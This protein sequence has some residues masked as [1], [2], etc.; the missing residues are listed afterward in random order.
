M[1]WKPQRGSHLSLHQQILGWMKERI[2]RG[3]W[4]IHTKLPPQRKLAEALEV[5]RSTIIHV[6]EELIA[7]GIL[8]TRPGDGTYVINNSWNM[9]ARSRNLDWQQ[10]ITSSMHE[11][12]MLTV[13]LINEYEQRN[14]IIRLGTGE[15]APELLPLSALKESIQKLTLTA[16]DIGY[17]EPKGSLELRRVLSTHLARK[18]IHASPEGILIVSGALQ[19]LQLISLGMLEPG[20]HVFHEVPSYLNSVHPFRSI[21][22]RMIPLE[23]DKPLTEVLHACPRKRQ[24][25][26]YTIPTLRNPT[27][28]IMNTEDRLSLLQACTAEH[29]P[30]I[31]DDVYGELVFTDAPPPLKALD[32]SGQVLYLG[33]VSK[34]LSPGLRIG[35]VVGPEPVI[36]RLADIKMQTDYGSSAFS[37]H[38]VRY[39]LDSGM[40]DAHLSDL[41]QRLQQRSALVED[42]LQR[43][44]SHL[45]TWKASEGGFYIWLRLNKP[46]AQKNLFSKL[47]K[48]GVLINPG[49]I[50]DP[51][52]MYHIR[53]SYAY[54]SPEQLLRG[55]TILQHAVDT[56]AV[57]QD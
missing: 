38:I 10:Y 48:Q 14:D 53:L 1:D 44:F 30:I 33:S 16:K 50:Y 34:T 20:S 2:S 35:W 54:A 25:L 32:T 27:G 57:T 43:Q 29:I 9:L 24:S 19:A 39:W 28:S 12:N 40:Y 37:Q 23:Q 31:E 55:L 3:Q 51:K 46:L 22:M 49:Y 42:A 45:A 36:D 47:I 4:P 41:K 56:E 5:N 8:E 26:L 6:M 17:S 21:G 13:Q 7:D 52:D 18:G 15:L 11:P